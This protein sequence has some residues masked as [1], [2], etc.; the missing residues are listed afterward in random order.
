MEC[1]TRREE[2][3]EIYKRGLK[4]NTKWTMVFR[5]VVSFMDACDARHPAFRGNPK[6]LDGCYGQSIS[7]SHNYHN[8]FPLNFITQPIIR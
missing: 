4:K 8:V 2:N 5:L 7:L 1:G 3:Q 6:T